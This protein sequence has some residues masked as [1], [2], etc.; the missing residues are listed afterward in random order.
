MV[1]VDNGGGAPATAAVLPVF[2]RVL[3]LTCQRETWCPLLMCARVRVCA[4]SVGVSLALSKGRRKAAAEVRLPVYRRDKRR[5]CMFV[6][7]PFVSACSRVH[8]LPISV[9][10][11]CASVCTDAP[12]CASPCHMRGWHTLGK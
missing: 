2:V 3:S 5:W 7:M 12:I 1:A 8:C 10:A 6:C 9:C 11:R 4:L